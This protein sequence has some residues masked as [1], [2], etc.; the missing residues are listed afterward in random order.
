MF[1]VPP[2]THECATTLEAAK[3]DFFLEY[4]LYIGKIQPSGRGSEVQRLPRF[5]GNAVGHRS[6]AS[7]SGSACTRENAAQPD[8]NMW[9]SVL[10]RADHRDALPIYAGRFSAHAYV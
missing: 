5:P 3:S 8:D 4:S 1:A 2:I 10:G 9:G 6:H 7:R